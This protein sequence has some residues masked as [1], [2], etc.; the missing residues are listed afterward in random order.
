MHW[1]V[2]AALVLLSLAFVLEAAERLLRAW[3]E[4]RDRKATHGRRRI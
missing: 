2:G 4:T 1:L 3:D